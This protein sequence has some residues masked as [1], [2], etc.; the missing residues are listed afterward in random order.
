MQVVASGPRGEGELSGG[1]VRL[2]LWPLDGR[3]K[4]GHGELGG[5]VRLI[6]PLIRNP[7][8]RSDPQ[9]FQFAVQG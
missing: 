2:R 4:P 6:P 7:L 8:R 3:V 5:L 9:R 1:V